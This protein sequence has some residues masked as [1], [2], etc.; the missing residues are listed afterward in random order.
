MLNPPLTQAG[1]DT[2]HVETR[3]FIGKGYQASFDGATYQR[4]RSMDGQA[5]PEIARGSVAD[6]DAAVGAARTAFEAGTWRDLD[7]SER[8]AVM[9]R[10]A[11]LIRENA[12]EL[13]LLETHDTGR[14]VQAAL[15]VDV[16][17]AANSIAWYG[18]LADKQYDEVA[19]TGPNDLATIRRMALGVVGVITPWNYPLIVTAWKL[20]PALAMGNSVVHKPAEQSSLS[21]IR[22]AGLAREAGLPEGV[23]NVVTGFGAEAGD[24]LAHHMDVDLIAFT[25]STAVGRLIMA[26][27][28]NS[29]LKRVALELGGKSP[30][31][32]FEDADLDKAATALAWGFA[33]HAG[34]TCHAPTRLLCHESKVKDLTARIQ[35]VLKDI[36]TGHPFDA[37]SQ[38]G[39]VI[40]EKQLERILDFVARAKDTGDQVLFGAERILAHTG[41][42]YVSPGIVLTDNQSEIAREEV[43]GPILSMVPFKTEAEA[44]QM[45]NDSPYG[46][47][48]AVFTQNMSL[49]NRMSNDLRAG[50]VWINTYDQANMATPFGGFK[51]SGF[52]RDRSIHALDK[53][54]DLKTVWQ[55][56]DG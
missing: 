5:G 17:S 46:L 19:P 27:A 18:E 10:F 52:G 33:Y 3:H 49:A 40:D 23:L 15:S 25:G 12:H 4:I 45:A 20:G 55:N 53:Y 8:K 9:L 7:P 51:Q 47:A 28:A 26:N 36:P 38:V 43:F 16:A 56:F 22:L 11:A 2:L 31:V 6:V 21:A 1:L 37:G 41:G 50:T 34:Q 48:A 44:L 13:A 29:N 35:T 32:V 42:C 30:V 24:A 39:A 54:A 14:P